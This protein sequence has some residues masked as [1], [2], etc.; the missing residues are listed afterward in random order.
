LWWLWYPVILVSFRGENGLKSCHRR[1]A[2]LGVALALLFALPSRPFAH[3]IPSD[4]RVQMF[5]HPEGQRLRVLVRFP[6]SSAADSVQWPMTQP[7]MLDLEKADAPLRQA[8]EL[9]I[10]DYLTVYEGDRP[11]ARPAIAAV[12]ASQPSDQSF[13]SYDQA[14]AHVTGQP[15]PPR[16]ELVIA[17][18][19]VDALLDYQIQSDQSKFSI[20]PNFAR[21]GVEVLTVMRFQPPNG[22]ERAFQ[23]HNDPGLVRLDPRWFQAAWTFVVEGF[24]HILG[25]FDHLL[26]LLCLVIPFRRMR[27]LVVIVTAFTVAHSITLIASAY[28]LAPDVGWFPPLV[29]TL[30]AASIVYM[31]LENIVKPQLRR[32]WLITFCFGLVHGF[33]F[34]FALR[35]TLQFAGAHL[36][37]SLLSFN[38]GVEIGQ[39]LVLAVFVPALWLLFRFG[40]NERSGT[41]ILSALVAHT[42]W[43][44]MSERFGRLI[45]YQFILPAFDASFFLM[46]V[47]WL[48]VLT[49]AAAAAW[50]I[51]GLLRKTTY[52]AETQTENP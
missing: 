39:L 44:W 35:D 7:G 50:M 51:S 28:N 24:F 26:F 3:E 13:A 29:E 19:L 47:R 46:M 4:A 12:M 18:G 11:L 49:I 5:V 32:R 52:N 20:H 36:L 37:T 42:G 33:G 31:A 38:V 30:I 8:A 41:I 10:V 2:G 1:V 43:H 45:R 48:M 22:T 27:S 15:L 17:Q 23:L 25:G 6:I 40:I 14:L 16:T 9:F 34:S 21:L